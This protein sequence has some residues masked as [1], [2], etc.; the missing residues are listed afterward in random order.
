MARPEWLEANPGS[1]ERLARA[2]VRTTRWL[3]EQ[4]AEQ[5]HGFRSRTG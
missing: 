3:R 2:M 4:N 1:A 5:G